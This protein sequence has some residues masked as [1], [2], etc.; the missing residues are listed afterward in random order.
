MLI[1]KP[2][3]Q[4]RSRLTEKLAKVRK[5]MRAP[6]YMAT[7][8]ENQIDSSVATHSYENGMSDVAT[9]QR[10]FQELIQW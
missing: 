9:S 2:G 3:R 10:I 8:G 1:K 5:N 6:Y 4:T 7:P